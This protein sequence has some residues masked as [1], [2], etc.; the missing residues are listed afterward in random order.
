M[1]LFLPVPIA[2]EDR[3]LTS[4]LFSHFIV[5]PQ[6]FMNALNALTKPFEAPQR[7]VKIKI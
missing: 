2:E 1:A 5:V 4:I 3:K 6:G 7:S